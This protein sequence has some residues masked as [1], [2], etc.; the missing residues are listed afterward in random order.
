VFASKPAK[1]SAGIS[2]ETSHSAARAR[3]PPYPR[4]CELFCM[5]ASGRVKGGWVTVPE[6]V[7]TF[8]HARERPCEGRLGRV[9]FPLGAAYPWVLRISRGR[10]D[11]GKSTL[12]T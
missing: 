2:T 9:V 11:A 6:I 7:R 4:S 12:V 3:H 8:L 5:P 10:A 1:L